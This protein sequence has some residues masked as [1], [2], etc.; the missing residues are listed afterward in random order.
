MEHQFRGHREGVAFAM[1]SGSDQPPLRKGPAGRLPSR[2]VSWFFLVFTSAAPFLLDGCAAGLV[3]AIFGIKEATDSSSSDSAPPVITQLEHESFCARSEILLKV[4]TEGE[5]QNRLEYRIE[6]T[7]LDVDPPAS[8]QP[9]TAA[10][11]SG[12]EGEVPVPGWA[13][14]LWQARQDLKG[15]SSR[16]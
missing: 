16:V 2:A 11:E 15:G 7:R 5:D 10:P 8:P 3:G 6:Y 4:R 14:F 12:P 9:A 1:T 13:H